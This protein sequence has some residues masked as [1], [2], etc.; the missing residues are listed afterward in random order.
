MIILS[1]LLI[2]LQVLCLL[3]KRR[4]PPKLL[5]PRSH[6]LRRRLPQLKNQ[7]PLHQGNLN[8][9]YATIIARTSTIGQPDQV[10]GKTRRNPIAGKSL[11][12]RHVFAT[13][14]V[15]TEIVITVSARSLE[16]RAAVVLPI[17]SS[18]VRFISEVCTLC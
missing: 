14:L 7:R 16:F 13:L 8:A 17:S 12:I 5:S 9:M 15:L 11:E 4:S 3:P 10:H 2:R 18:K 1:A 6:L